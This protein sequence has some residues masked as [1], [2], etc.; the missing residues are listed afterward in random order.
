VSEVFRQAACQP[1]WLA[2]LEGERN[3]RDHYPPVP[4]L[5][6]PELFH[7]EEQEDDHGPPGVL[8]VLQHL[9]QAHGTQRDEVRA[10]FSRWLFVQ[11]MDKSAEPGE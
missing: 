11:K 3:A 6:K 8:K 1:K 10:V 5:Q 7:H 2:T 4:G 9:P